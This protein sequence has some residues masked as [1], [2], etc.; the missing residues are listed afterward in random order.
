MDVMLTYTRGA[1][2]LGFRTSLAADSPSSAHPHKQALPASLRPLAVQRAKDTQGVGF[3]NRDHPHIEGYPLT[4][5][6]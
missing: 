2:R 3:L 5:A 4:C 6:R 1:P